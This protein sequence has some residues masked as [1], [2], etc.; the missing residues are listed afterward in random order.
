VTRRLG[1]FIVAKPG[2][3]P[4]IPAQRALKPFRLVPEPES[5]NAAK[6][7]PP[8]HVSVHRLTHRST[9]H[10]YTLCIFFLFL[11]RPL[12][13]PLEFL[14]PISINCSLATNSLSPL[15]PCEIPSSRPS[16][17]EPPKRR[18]GCAI[19]HPLIFDHQKSRTIFEARRRTRQDGHP[20]QMTVTKVSSCISSKHPFLPN[21]FPPPSPQSTR[22]WEYW[23]L[24]HKSAEFG[25]LQQQ[26]PNTL[27]PLRQ[28]SNP[29]L[30]ELSSRQN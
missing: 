7:P 30:V 15:P 25:W 29:T 21:Y 9:T 18:R 24:R 26:K 12:S 10:R 20:S 11:L 14:Y 8:I 22:G 27:S 16:S 23:S 1:V 5:P 4:L 19:L 2:K 28:G 6:P 13:F 3:R 17:L